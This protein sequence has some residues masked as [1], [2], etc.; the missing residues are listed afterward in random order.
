MIDR[1]LIGALLLGGLLAGCAPFPSEQKR[2]T[3][4]FQPQPTE[5]KTLEIPELEPAATPGGAVMDWVEASGWREGLGTDY[6]SLEIHHQRRERA[7]VFV[8]N[9]RDDAVRDHEYRLTLRERDDGWAVTGVERR[10]ICRRGLSG[11]GLC[12]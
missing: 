11:D 4:V 9:L 2:A 8:K 10:V 12:R 3:D 1:R 6:S 5:R 7:E